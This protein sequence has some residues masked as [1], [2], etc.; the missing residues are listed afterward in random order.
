MWPQVLGGL[1]PTGL[2]ALPGALLP[3]LAPWQ[4]S[5]TPSASFRLL[6]PIGLYLP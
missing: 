5:P 3:L 6:Q 2:H 1:N 4:P